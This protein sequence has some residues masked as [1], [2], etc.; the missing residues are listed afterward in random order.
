MK[1]K[2]MLNLTA[3]CLLMLAVFACAS[4]GGG[5]NF[6]NNFFGSFRLSHIAF[7]A[8]HQQNG[9]KQLAIKPST[10]KILAR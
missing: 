7:P 4:G 9:S 5:I 3:L 10:G 1:P 2:S 8:H 6:I